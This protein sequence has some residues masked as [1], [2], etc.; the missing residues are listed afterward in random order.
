M[1]IFLYGPDA[2]RREA[3]RKFYLQEFEKKHGA[4]AERIDLAEDGTER[5]ERF[6]ANQSLF[7][8]SRLAA[9]GSLYE[10]EPKKIS[11]FLKASLSRKDVHLLISETKKPAKALE[12][13]IK[14]PATALAFENLA[15][16]A[17]VKFVK[18][19]AK[20]RKLA[21]ADPALAYLAEAFEGNSWALATELDKLAGKAGGVSP[22]DLKGMGIETPHEYWP[23][24]NSLRGGRLADR[25]RALDILLGGN[26]PPA[27]TFHMIASLWSAKTSQFAAYDTAV[28]L[29]KLDYE[30]ALLDLIVQQ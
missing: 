26:E 24:I 5:L 15:G 13:L 27:K 9:V 29:S 6:L 19:E 1:I 30:E 20:R 7:N 25:L 4:G 22:D 2:Y 8:K 3:K 10:E 18:D 12:F 28:K 23:V 11:P 14:P 21:L 16:S 17:W